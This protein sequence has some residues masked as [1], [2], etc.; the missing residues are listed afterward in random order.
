M[1]ANEK[2]FHDMLAE[3]FSNYEIQPRPGEGH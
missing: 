1:G 2:E 3:R